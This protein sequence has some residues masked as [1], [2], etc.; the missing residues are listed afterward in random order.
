MKKILSPPLAK[1]SEMSLDVISLYTNNNWLSDWLIDSI[2]VDYVSFKHDSS[3]TA[4]YLQCIQTLNS[5][6]I[7]F[8]KLHQQLPLLVVEFIICL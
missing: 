8:T 6:L 5:P 2:H 1:R 3:N 7:C 4:A